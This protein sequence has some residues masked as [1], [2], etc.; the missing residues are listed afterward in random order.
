MAELRIAPARRKRCPSLE[1]AEGWVGWRVDDINGSA[2]GEVDCLCRDA[3]GAPAWLVVGEDHADGRRRFAVPAADAVG[4]VGRVWS[5]HT[6]RQIRSARIAGERVD[7]WD[8]DRLFA[9]YAQGRR[10]A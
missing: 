5:P 6:R 4:C 8:E 10:A 2:V 1:E 9:H 3:A 7:P